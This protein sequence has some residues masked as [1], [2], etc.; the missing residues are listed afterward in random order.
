[1]VA[2]EAI[3]VDVAKAEVVDVHA[4][5]TVKGGNLKPKT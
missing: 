1:V 2:A 5:A 3:P 4:V